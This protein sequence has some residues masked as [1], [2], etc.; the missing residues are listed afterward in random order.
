MLALPSPPED[1]ARKPGTE[2]KT[3]AA[4]VGALL[5]MVSSSMVLTE[6][7]DFI[8]DAPTAVPV[9]TTRSRFRPS[10]GAVGAAGVAA[11]A[12][13][14]VCCACAAPICSIATATAAAMQPSLAIRVSIFVSGVVRGCIGAAPVISP[15][16]YATSANAGQVRHYS[17]NKNLLQ[18]IAYKRRNMGFALFLRKSEQINLGE[19]GT[20]TG[21]G[22]IF[23]LRCSMKYQ[24]KLKIIAIGCID[25]QV[26]DAR[27]TSSVGNC[28]ETCGAPSTSASRDDTS[29]RPAARMGWRTVLNG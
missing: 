8:F 2:R 23:M 13:S 20:I 22:K 19:M 6:L 29:A 7:L 9:T 5:R 15:V 26:L 27:T 21:N 25:D 11:A 18:S 14:V 1:S 16:R 10:V 12:V 24:E 3:S 17:S 28:C 4:L